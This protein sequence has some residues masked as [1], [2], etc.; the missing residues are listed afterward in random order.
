MEWYRIKRDLTKKHKAKFFYKIERLELS[1]N[2]YEQ[3]SDRNL[4][5]RQL[6]REG[7]GDSGVYFCE[8][9][10]VFDSMKKINKVNIL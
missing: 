4:I 5:I 1:L 3:L 8:R 2:K 9:S 6:S 7:D 10:H